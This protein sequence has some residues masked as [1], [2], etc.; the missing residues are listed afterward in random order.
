M[1]GGTLLAIHY[2]LHL[3]YGL[4]TGK[5]LWDAMSSPLGRIDGPVFTASFATMDLTLIA[6]AMAY[7][8]QLNAI[9]FGVL[10]FGVV[11]FLCAM[12]GFVATLLGNMVPYVMPVACLTMF[13][14]AILLSIATLK[15]RVL[16]AW[17][18]SGLL[19]FGVFTAPL[20]FALPNLKPMLPE[21]A[22]FELHF[23][24][25]ALLWVAM[26]IALARQHGNRRGTGQAEKLVTRKIP[27]FKETPEEN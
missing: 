6:I 20:G 11:A 14:S 19:A 22:L 17:V 3:T 5:I 9:K 18:R 1:L 10:F 25:P 13:L 4:Q 12:T 21:F 24:F 16:P 7:Y 2:F 23:M 27:A 8:R 26:G 15:A